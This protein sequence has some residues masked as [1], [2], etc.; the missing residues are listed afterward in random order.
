MRHLVQQLGNLLL[1]TLAGLCAYK[2]VHMVTMDNITMDAVTMDPVAMGD[3]EGSTGYDVM[4]IL[5][6]VI[7]SSGIITN[8][9]VVIVFLNDKKLRRK[10]PNICIINQVGVFQLFSCFECVDKCDQGSEAWLHSYPESHST[11]I[12]KTDRCLKFIMHI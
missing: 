4:E 11:H 8:L 10:T 12:F 3:R 2:T 6:M 7:A 5:Q 9:T 1:Q